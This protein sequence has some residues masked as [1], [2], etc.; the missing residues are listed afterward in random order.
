MRE[1]FGKMMEILESVIST[2]VEAVEST[3]SQ[4]N[5]EMESAKADLKKKFPT[6][7]ELLEA[8]ARVKVM[9]L[10]AL[11]PLQMAV[12]QHFENL[13][14]ASEMLPYVNT[15]NNVTTA[16]IEEYMEILRG[17][18]ETMSTVHLNKV[19]REHKLTNSSNGSKGQ[20][21]R[22]EKYDPL[23]QKAIEMARAGSYDSRNHAAYQIS[24]KIIDLPEF[25]N[26]GMSAQSAKDT[27][28][29]W[30]KKEN[31]GFGKHPKMKN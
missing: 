21:K 23:R 11:A 26:A 28:A 3:V 10:Q 7:P 29:R 1:S 12:G 24:L 30:L 2:D 5:A 18:V 15:Q 16:E 19:R 13:I 17:S 8:A 20:A 27:V 4:W 22:D 14:K 9:S 25:K 31:I 6:Y